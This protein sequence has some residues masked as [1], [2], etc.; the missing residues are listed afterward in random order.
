MMLLTRLDT[1]SAYVSSVLPAEVLLG[2]G[3][4]CVFVPAISTATARVDRRDA[5]VASAVVNTSQQVGGSV[6][7]ALLNTVAA[8][9]TA[10]YLAGHPRAG[11]AGLVHGYSVAAGWGA[12]ILLTAALLTLILVNAGRPSPAA[13]EPTGPSPTEPPR[14]APN[15]A[16]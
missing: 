3:I 4:G 14:A 1:D 15:P 10:S 16:A 9:A 2:L 8:T 11:A 7:T 6:G 12:A 5:G 13:F